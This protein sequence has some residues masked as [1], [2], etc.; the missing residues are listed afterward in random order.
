MKRNPKRIYLFVG[1]LMMLFLGLI[2]AWSIFRAPLTE[3]FPDWTATQISLTFT[4][5]MVC[6][7]TGAF[8]AGRIEPFVKNGHIVMISAILLLMGFGTVSLLIDAES[9][10]KSLYI[11]YAFY[12]I[13][14][15]G[16]VGM[17][18]NSVLSTLTKWFPE[19]TGLIS[20]VLLMSF[21]FGGMVLGSIVNGFVAVIGIKATFAVIGAMVSAVLFTGSFV[22]KSPQRALPNHAKTKE[23]VEDCTLSK[24]QREKT[25]SST[26]KQYT[27]SEMLRTPTFWSFCL[28]VVSVC[29]GGLLIMNSAATIAV[30]FGAPAVLGL[31]VSV[32]NGVGRV[33][34]GG[35]YDRYGR[36]VSMTADA[37]IMILAG[38]L[39]YLGARTANTI[40]I[41]VGLPLIG[42]S[43][44]GAPSVSSAV[45]NSYYGSKHYAVNFATANFSLAPAAVI[46]PLISSK[47]YESA[48]GA[49]DSTFLMIVFTS[50]FALVL[51]F[52]TTGFSKRDCFE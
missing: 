12:G 1:T 37:V 38:I 2:Y 18:Y 42:I 19:K 24:E 13:V 44:A 36:R 20:G 10:T 9:P 15:G 16:G 17:S 22:V 34:I 30:A 7:C 41:L 5:S 25:I 48:G 26:H 45:I 47:L 51:S 21:G 14:C 40:F 52:V 4:I 32:F 28:W 39:L 6:F 27:L 46:G 33:A 31:M 11:L 8:M 50:V 3:L 49:Y 23:V 43:Y 35:L 29:T